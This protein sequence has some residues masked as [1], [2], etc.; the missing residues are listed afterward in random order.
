MLTNPHLHRLLLELDGSACPQQAVRRA[1]AI[2]VFVE[3]T[4][5]CLRLCGLRESEDM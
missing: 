4:D 1:M 3:F 5:E 2:P